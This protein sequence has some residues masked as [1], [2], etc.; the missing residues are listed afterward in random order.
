MGR[1][2]KDGRTYHKFGNP[3]IEIARLSNPKVVTDPYFAKLSQPY[4]S[5]PT[6][7]DIF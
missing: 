6:H 5:H 2:R 7:P 4:L 3:K 1:I